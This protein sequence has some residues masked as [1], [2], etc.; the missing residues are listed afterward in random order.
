MR[1]CLFDMDGLLIDSEDKYTDITNAI[2][3]E[4]GKPLLP[5]SIKAQLQG[6]PQPDV[7]RFPF[8]PPPP[9]VPRCCLCPSHIARIANTLTAIFKPSVF[10]PLTVH[11]RPVVS[12]TIGPN[13]PS[14]L[15]NTP[16]SN[17]PFRRNSSLNPSPS[18]A[19]GTSSP[20]L[21]PPKLP[22]SPCI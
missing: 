10:N 9:Q 5:W 11:S 19:S 8:P 13:S 20:S 15:K 7:C 17:P 18:R 21:F 2:L 4:Y 16:R 22:I 6:R 3:Q 1:A 12:S 14:L